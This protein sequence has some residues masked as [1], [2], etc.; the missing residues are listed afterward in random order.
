MASASVIVRDD[1]GESDQTEL[2]LI[3]IAPASAVPV[4]E[5]GTAEFILFASKESNT[6]YTIEVGL[7]N[8]NGDFIDTT[9]EA[10]TTTELLDDNDMRIGERLMTEVMMPAN[11]TRVLLEIPT[12][13]DMTEEPD[14]EIIAVIVI[15]D[16]SSYRIASF[17]AETARLPV[18][19]VNPSESSSV[20][21]VVVMDDDAVPELSIAYIPS[22]SDTETT[23]VDEGAEVEI[24]ISAN[25]LSYL[26]KVVLVRYD[27]GEGD[28]V[29]NPATVDVTL[30]AG[31]MSTRFSI[32]TVD[33]EDGEAN[34]ELTV[35][36][37]SDIV[38]PVNYTVSTTNAT[39][40]VNIDDN[41]GGV[42]LP[43]IT[44]EVD[45]STIVE[46]N[47]VKFYIISSTTLDEVL[48][49]NIA[50]VQGAGEDFL[51]TT[52]SL[53]DNVSFEAG[54]NLAIVEL[55]TIDDST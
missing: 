22:G 21:A 39:A 7:I 27:D 33:D 36:L 11:E 43:Q 15:G 8:A 23:P 20:A 14:G 53:P 38:V 41:D 12:S 35:L 31:S 25:R 6:A 9:T 2:P 45:Q 24:E 52:P 37:L 26:D 29:E 32:Q 46:G 40:M 34:G 28:F 54:K 48:D 19:E 50:V 30:P 17:E 51:V 18:V 47:D 16:D 4:V 49:V 42:A 1:D 3:S 10:I 44:V 55:A 5:G 13:D